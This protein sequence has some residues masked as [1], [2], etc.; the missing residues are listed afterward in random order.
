MAL[1]DDCHQK[2]KE[3]I[4]DDDTVSIPDYGRRTW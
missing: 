4:F 2:A 3:G 1:C